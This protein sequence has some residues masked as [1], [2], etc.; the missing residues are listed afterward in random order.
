MDTGAPPADLRSNASWVRLRNVLLYPHVWLAL[1]AAAQ[2]W[3]MG[4]VGPSAN[5]KGIVGTAASVIAGYGYLRI[6]RA[7]E[8]DPIPS[9]HILWVRQHRSAMVVL[10]CVSAAASAFLFW[11]QHLVF[12]NWSWF[13]LALCAFY[14]LPIRSA[15]GTSFGLREVPGM[16]IVVVALAWTFITCGITDVEPWGYRREMNAWMAVLQFGF[17]LAMAIAF[18][19]GD[20]RYDRP[21]LRTVPQLLGTRGAK[22]LALLFLLPWCG[23]LI[24]RLVISYHPFEPGWREP[25][26]DMGL[27]LPLSG[28]VIIGFVIAKTNPKR[29]HWYFAVLLDGLLLVLP[30]L[31]WLGGRM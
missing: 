5:W 30:L 26:W 11:G 24:M 7:S 14:L 29:P 8:P 19:I 9:D 16:K 2:R 17:F 13:V 23:F 10:V 27:L 15:S 18:D 1:G 12:G 21:G 25:R 22:V 4:E 31:A 6:V 20:I 28:M 3:W